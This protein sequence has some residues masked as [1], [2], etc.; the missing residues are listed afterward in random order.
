MNIPV[1]TQVEEDS[2]DDLVVKDH[3]TMVNNY[4][5]HHHAN[6]ASYPPT[7]EQLL[8]QYH[9]SEEDNDDE[10]VDFDEWDDEDDAKE[11]EEEKD[12]F[13]SEDDDDDN[14]CALYTN[15]FEHDVE[16]EED[17]KMAAK[18]DVTGTADNDDVVD[19]ECDDKFYDAV[20]EE[21][22]EKNDDSGKEELN[23]IGKGAFASG[24]NIL[25]SNNNCAR[26]PKKKATELKWSDEE[27]K[28]P[29]K[30]RVKTHLRS[31]KSVS[32]TRT[33]KR[34]KQTRLPFVK[35]PDSALAH[36]L[37]IQELLLLTRDAFKKENLRPT[38]KKDSKTKD[39]IDG[40]ENKQ[41]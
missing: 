33:P 19:V 21:L 12:Y 15:F 40:K 14:T 1:V 9:S 31:K 41:N 22:G 34:K 6:V 10:D 37:H 26:S 29:K 24:G 20:E 2:D 16:E 25:T 36:S 7:E 38:K 11:K 27:Q 3:P 30:I 13:D 17:C 23:N 35:S 32:S 5:H 39:N 18:E 8:L 4:H 28:S